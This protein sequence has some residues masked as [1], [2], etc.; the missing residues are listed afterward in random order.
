M[1][2]CKNE[3][4]GLSQSSFYIKS[5]TWILHVTCL[6]SSRTLRPVFLCFTCLLAFKW[7]SA[8]ESCNNI[9]KISAM[10]NSI[11]KI[12]YALETKQHR[13]WFWKVLNQCSFQ[14]VLLFCCLYSYECVLRALWHTIFSWTLVNSISSKR[15][16]FRIPKP[17][18]VMYAGFLSGR[19][20]SQL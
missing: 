14:L 9:K 17:H 15:S 8:W 1:K 2:G 20:R 7:C 12:L 19:M 18:S 13:V 11:W 3:T 6:Q 10:R 16:Q 4:F 5:D